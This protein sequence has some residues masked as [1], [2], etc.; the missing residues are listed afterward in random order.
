MCQ[1]ACKRNTYKNLKKKV[2]WRK[3]TKWTIR[4]WRPCKRAQRLFPHCSP[5]VCLCVQISKLRDKENVNRKNKMYILHQCQLNLNLGWCWGALSSFPEDVSICVSS[6][7]RNF[8][9]R[10]TFAVSLMLWWWVAMRKFKPV[11]RIIPCMKVVKVC[12]RPD[13]MMGLPFPD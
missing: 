7:L 5:G 6:Y 2:M 13:P 8:F 12:L 9:S 10:V 4:K 1:E 11:S 3:L